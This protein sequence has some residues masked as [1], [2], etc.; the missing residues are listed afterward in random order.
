M[1]KLPLTKKQ[2]K[3]YDFIEK[4]NVKHGACPMLADIAAALDMAPPN[5]FVIVDELVKKHWLGKDESVRWGI[6]IP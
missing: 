1:T 6:F 5:V 4:F 2:Q 3:I